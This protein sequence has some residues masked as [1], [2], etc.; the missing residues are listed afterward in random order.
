MRK[1]KHVEIRYHYICYFVK[2]G[3][4]L[5]A[6]VV[7]KAMSLIDLR[8]RW[9]KS[10]S[11]EIERKLKLPFSTRSPPPGGVLNNLS[12]NNFSVEDSKI[13]PK[14]LANPSEAFWILLFSSI[15]QLAK[16]FKSALSPRIRAPLSWIKLCEEQV[17]P[18]VLFRS[19]NI[20]WQL[21]MPIQQRRVPE[22]TW[23]VWFCSLLAELKKKIVPR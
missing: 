6:Y 5:W 18:C 14:K 23:I 16:N 9:R 13:S 10:S 2:S 20:S 22:R 11:R 17:V 7:L 3:R 21:P 15:K 4:M 8:N 12:F 1:A 19:C